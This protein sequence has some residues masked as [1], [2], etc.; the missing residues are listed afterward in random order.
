MRDGGR[1]SGGGLQD[2]PSNRPA[3]GG[4]KLP[5]GERTGKRREELVRCVPG[6]RTK[7]NRRCSVERHP[8]VIKTG[9]IWQPGIKSSRNLF[10][11]WTVTGSSAARAWHWLLCGTWEPGAPMSRERPKGKTPVRV[12]VPMRSAGADRLVIVTKPGNAGGAKG[13]NR[14]ASGMDQPERGG[15][16]A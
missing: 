7:V 5:G 12:R 13:P 3:L 10:T 2:Q 4:D 9:P 15:V 11:G 8:T 14:P 6:R 1:S 16:H